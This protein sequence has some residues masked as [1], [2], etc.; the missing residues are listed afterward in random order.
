MPSDAVKLAKIQ[1]EKELA[2]AGLNTFVNVLT[3]PAVMLIGGFVAVELLQRYPR[4]SPVLGPVS[5]TV[6]EGAL[7]SVPFLEALGKSSGPG[8]LAGLLQSAAPL[9]ALAAK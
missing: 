1:K 7:V 3:N 4:G 6:V 9:L 8:G 2:Q 5:G